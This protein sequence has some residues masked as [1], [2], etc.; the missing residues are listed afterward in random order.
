VIL[1]RRLLAAAVLLLG[2]AW[3]AST[4]VG[5]GSPAARVGEK[6]RPET[7]QGKADEHR[8]AADREAVAKAM[9]RSAAEAAALGG[10]IET[11]V[12]AA[13]WPQ[14][15][16]V[17][18]EP[19]GAG[20]WMR[21]WSMSKIVTMVALLRARGWGEE[22]GKPL[23]AEVDAA[24]EGAIARSENCP[25]RRVVVELQEATGG[26]EGAREAVAE[27]LALA[28]AGARPAT[29]IAGPDPGC[30][31]YLEGQEQSA[32][33]LAATVL[34]GTSTWRVEDAARFM[35][36]LAAGRYGK[37]VSE[38]V[39]RAMRE[40][41]GRSREVLSSEFTAAVDWGAGRA[42]ADWDPAYKGGWGGAD[43]SAFLAGQMVVLELP[44]GGRAELAVMYHPEVQPPVD[45]PGLTVA[46][47]GVELVMR[48]VRS[49]LR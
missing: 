18:S 23:P 15:I 31:E 2:G 49:A 6:G 37:A 40:P 8:A 3:L 4:L 32:D 19:G 5:G 22:P 44:G 7:P 21:M 38:R 25:Q 45:D 29:E 34:L 43:R 27:T 28:G 24:L 46:P 10:T 16:V 47:E 30:V 17:S 9:K 11:A 1:R 26:P 42:F 12:L 35:A 14:P 20:R 33:P 13:G 48:A 36:A 39:L 41:K